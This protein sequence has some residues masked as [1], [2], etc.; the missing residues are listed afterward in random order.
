MV[1]GRDH[2]TLSPMGIHITYQRAMLT[3]IVKNLVSALTFDI[4]R[5][6][7]DIK[8]HQDALQLVMVYPLIFRS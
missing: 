2:V 3:Y 4:K 5:M 1:K 6:D 7:G 8:S